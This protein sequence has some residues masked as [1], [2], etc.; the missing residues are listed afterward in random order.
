[1]TTN[2]ASKAPD[3]I[4]ID[5]TKYP[6]LQNMGK[7]V[8][9]LV[10]ETLSFLDLAVQKGWHEAT[11]EYFERDLQTFIKEVTGAF[12]DYEGIN[13]HAANKAEA[14]VLSDEL[15]YATNPLYVAL[16]KEGGYDASLKF[17]LEKGFD[18]KNWV[19]AMLYLGRY[20]NYPDLTR[21][22][23]LNG[24]ELLETEKYK[25]IEKLIEIQPALRYQ[26][27]NEEAGFPGQLIEGTGFFDCGREPEHWEGVCPACKMPTH[28]K[29]EEFKEYI[30]CFSCKAGFRK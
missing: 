10:S 30:A 4:P 22:L 2:G 13:S 17:G 27:D 11:K 29:T 28:E 1:M 18:L 26:R 14:K 3:K 20:Y 5:M 23:D 6:A 12:L 7:E 25:H 16:G 21:G 15:K 19:S 9:P 8:M 24:Y